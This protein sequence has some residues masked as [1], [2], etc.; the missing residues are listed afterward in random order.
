MKWSVGILLTALLLA[1]CRRDVV[2][3]EQSAAW[4]QARKSADA[5]EW[6][7][8][9]AFY[10][11]TIDEHPGFA[12]AHLELGLLQDEKLNDPTAAIYH[13]RRYLQQEPNSDKRRVV[14]DFIERA[15][16]SLAAKL[17]QV[18]GV[19][20]GELLRLQNQNAALAAEVAGLKAKL[21]EYEVAVSAPALPAVDGA[22]PVMPTNR[23]TPVEA[24]PRTHVVQKGDTLYSISLRYYGN[25]SAWEKIYQANKA[26]LPSKDQLKVGQQ[27]LIP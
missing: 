9:A 24:R 5:G 20:T 26:A 27:L 25:A 22:A 14:E 8:A 4:Q 16:L 13:Y 11:Q 3:P 2:A 18:A 17:P 7:A 19:D 15:R 21:A 1:G 10:Q 12:R 23:P 6:K